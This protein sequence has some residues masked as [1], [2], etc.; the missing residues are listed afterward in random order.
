M[1]KVIERFE[2]VVVADDGV[3]QIGKHY[4]GVGIR[5]VHTDSAIEVVAA[6]S[7]AALEIAAELGLFVFERLEHLLCQVLFEQRFGVFGS[8][9]LCEELVHSELDEVVVVGLFGLFVGG[10]VGSNLR[11]GG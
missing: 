11:R 1:L 10:V 8:F 7:D 5:R 2:F 6:R 9:Q 3:E 4:I